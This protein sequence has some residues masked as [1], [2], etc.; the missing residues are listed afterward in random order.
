M[1]QVCVIASVL[2]L[3]GC[4]YSADPIAIG[5]YDAVTSYSSKLPGKYLLYVADDQLD[6]VVHPAGVACSA[7][8]FPIQAAE[9]FRGSVAA[10][11]ANLADKVEVIAEP[12][13]ADQL[14][15]KGARGLIVVRA[16]KLDGRLD[17]VPGFW[18]ANITTEMR[19]TASVTV[20]GPAGRL[21][22]STFD[23]F[24]RGDAPS[25]FACEGGAKAMKDG[26]EKAMK[27]IVRKIGEGISN[28]DRVRSG[29]TA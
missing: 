8:T 6:A 11:L 22:G 13:A 29:R 2:A 7:H 15:A 27:E 14:R 23:S 20:D 5:A 28:S 17:V 4:A 19:I 16:D 9:G 21:Y 12:V 26:T 3:T 24:G 25:G 1:K 10:T 18:S